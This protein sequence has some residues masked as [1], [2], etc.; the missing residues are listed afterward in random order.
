M[1]RGKKIRGSR[2]W[3]REEEAG[4]EHNSSL[5]AP[6]KHRLPRSWSQAFCSSPTLSSFL[7][8]SKVIKINN[9]IL[10]FHF[11]PPSSS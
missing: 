2:K 1:D 3:P 6:I 4:G 7:G 9:V 11:F 5:A 8:F 10:L